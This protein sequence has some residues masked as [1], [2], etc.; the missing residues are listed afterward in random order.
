[1]F[2]T[3]SIMVTWGL[4][5]RLGWLVSE[6]SGTFPSL[7]LQHCEESVQLF[8]WVLGIKHRSRC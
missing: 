6:P 2:E 8:M 5:I 3:G 1:M 7:L 4:L